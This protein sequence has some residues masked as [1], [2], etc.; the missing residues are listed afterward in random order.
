[1]YWALPGTDQRG[2]CPGSRIAGG[3]TLN[4]CDCRDEGFPEEVMSGQQHVHWPR[5]GNE[6]G[7]FKKFQEHVLASPNHLRALEM[8]KTPETLTRLHLAC[9]GVPATM[10][11]LRSRTYLT[12]ESLSVS[13]HGDS[14]SSLVL[15]TNSPIQDTLVKITIQIR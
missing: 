2:I 13:L 3:H 4:K 6:Y 1:M 5:V 12:P 11:H 10:T 15:F 8:E 9:S 14:L 7:L